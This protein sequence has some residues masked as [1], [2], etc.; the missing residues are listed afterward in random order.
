MRC[1]NT[2]TKHV[3]RYGTR[4]ATFV[5]PNDLELLHEIE[6]AARND[7]SAD[8]ATV[9][10]TAPIAAGRPQGRARRVD[11]RIE[12]CARLDDVYHNVGRRLRIER[13]GARY[14]GL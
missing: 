10:R 13:V 1:F 9:R 14:S 2:I 12:A 4:I 7:R 11:H 3:D 5:A 6:Q 8:S